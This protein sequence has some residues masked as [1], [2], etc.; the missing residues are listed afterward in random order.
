ML[1]HHLYQRKDF[2]TDIVA[3]QQN[4]ASSTAKR[5]NIVIKLS[6]DGLL[7]AT[8]RLTQSLELSYEESYPI[9]LSELT[10][11]HLIR[12]IHVESFDIG[13]RSA[14]VQ[15]RSKYFTRK[16]RQLIRSELKRCQVCRVLFGKISVIPYGPIP[17]Y[18]LTRSSQYDHIGLDIF[19]LSR[20]RNYY[21]LIITSLVTLAVHIEI[22]DSLSA[23]DLMFTLRDF[24]TQHMVSRTIL[25]DNGA[26]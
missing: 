24:S 18:R 11:R 8:T 5:W 20:T 2:F 3:L 6:D 19:N 14:L 13:L 12:Y 22:V 25:S 10:A 4:Q 16:S 9:I 7:R 21:G 1:V 17:S 26:N 15:F 23:A